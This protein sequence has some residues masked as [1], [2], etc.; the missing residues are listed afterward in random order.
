MLSHKKET[1]NPLR[2]KLLK[3]GLNRSA[4]DGLTSLK[5]SVLNF[6]LEPLLT[7]IVVNVNPS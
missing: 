6:T 4:S 3:E 5:Y 2:R 7:R 1:P